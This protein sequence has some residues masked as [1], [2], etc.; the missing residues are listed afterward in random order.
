MTTEA[1]ARGQGIRRDESLN[2]RQVSQNEIFA[3]EKI[4]SV[5]E[6]S[7]TSRGG[8]QYDLVAA[9]SNPSG[10]SSAYGLCE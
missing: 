5:I 3:R 7:K 1:P 9:M 6:W 4:R 8:R 10:C 2:R